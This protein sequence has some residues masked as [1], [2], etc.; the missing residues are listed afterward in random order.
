VGSAISRRLLLLQLTALSGAAGLAGCL[1]PDTTNPSPRLGST[2]GQLPRAWLQRLPYPWM[3]ESAESMADLLS[4]PRTRLDLLALS[5]GWA[6]QRAG[7]R[8]Q[9]LQTPALSDRLAPWVMGGGDASLPRP[10]H[11]RALPVAFSPWVIAHRLPRR[12]TSSP[13]ARWGFL[14]DPA[15]R[16]SLVLPSSLR[17]VIALAE[18]LPNSLDDLPHLR[19]QASSYDDRNALNLLLAGEAKA[20]VCQARW[21]IPLLQSDPRL[22]VM[23]PDQ[24]TVLGWTVLVRPA[25]SPEPLPQPWVDLAWEQPLLSRLARQG[26]CPPLERDVLRE[27]LKALP[28]AVA[29]LIAPPAPL[30]QR[31]TTLGPMTV[32][33]RRRLQEIWG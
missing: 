9:S 16:D 28:E 17:V 3:L 18:R 1:R 22:Q 25:S 33:E 15:L 11:D 2:P 4:E 27:T 13:P 20:V 10:L 32:Q 6:L 19:R 7:E 21:V 5:D 31:C 24:G 23:L 14:L 29:A 26:W 12:R 30:L 8:W